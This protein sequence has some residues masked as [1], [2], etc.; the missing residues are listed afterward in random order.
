MIYLILIFLSSC[1]SDRIF[2]KT[3]ICI[4][5]FFQLSMEVFP[6][7]TEEDLRRFRDW[8]TGKGEEHLCD[9]VSAVSSS[10]DRKLKLM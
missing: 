1:E 9:F 2:L 6:E 4:L 7:Y 3:A 10:D 5:I 8:E